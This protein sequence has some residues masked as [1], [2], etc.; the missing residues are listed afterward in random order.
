MEHL[1]IFLFAIW[2]PSWVRYLF[3]SLTDLNF[4]FL[5]VKF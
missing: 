5:I 2:I 3:R 4:F 1:C